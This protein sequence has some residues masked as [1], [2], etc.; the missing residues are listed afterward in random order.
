MGG[1]RWAHGSSGA[2][3]ARHRP[4]VPAGEVHLEAPP[5]IPRAVP[6]SALCC[7]CCRWS[8][9]SA[10]VGFIVV[11]GVDN[12]TSWLFGGMFALSTIGMVA[13]GATRGGGQ[14]RAEADE[15]RKDY[16]R[17]LAQMR[18]RARETAADQRRAL[19]WTHPDPTAL[20]GLARGPRMWER[21]PADADFAHVRVGRG[22]QR[23]ATA[24]VPPQT[25]PVDDLEP[26]A[27]VALRRF[28]RTHSI[29]PTCPPRCRCAPSRRWASPAPTR[30]AAAGWCGRCSRS[31]SRSHSPDDLVVAVAADGSGARGVGVGQVAPARRAPPALPTAPGPVR[32]VTS[33]LAAVESWLAPSSPGDPA[34]PAE[35]RR[36]RTPATWSSSLDDAEVTRVRADRARGGPAGGHA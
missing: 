17:Y 35:P 8:W 34:S 22:S 14:R 32:M 7:G 1:D 12:P 6:T 25:G 28:V 13:G 29:V 27:T 19:E 18:R 4:E 9:C 11:I 15:D 24:L 3:R 33:S 2:P 26:V 20:V 5:E 21:R 31:S 30:R 23:L 36:P 16:L 10:R